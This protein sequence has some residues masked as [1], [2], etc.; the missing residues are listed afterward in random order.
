MATTKKM[1]NKVAFE[2][3]ITALQASNLPD[4]DEAIAKVAKA[5]EQIEKKNSKTSGKL[6]A[7][8]TANLEIG[9]G[10]I[11]PRLGVYRTAVAIDGRIYS[12]VTNIGRCPTF[13]GE[14]TRLEAHLIGFD[15][16]LYDKEIKVYILGFLRDE[17][18]FGSL[19]ELKA[20][21]NLDR[22]RTIIENGELTWQALGQK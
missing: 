2:M 13:M 11:V 15:G 8:Q 4:K 1:T 16:N 19:D 9:E 22:E 6:T 12:A 21:I 3:A 7:K 17:R 20:Q 14:S 18:K 10:K 5:I